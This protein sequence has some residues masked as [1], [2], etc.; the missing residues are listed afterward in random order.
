MICERAQVI[1]ARDTQPAQGRV[2]TKTYDPLLEALGAE[3]HAQW[4]FDKLHPK[5]EKAPLVRRP[6]RT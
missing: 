1:A 5:R 4:A 3:Q 2:L 6:S